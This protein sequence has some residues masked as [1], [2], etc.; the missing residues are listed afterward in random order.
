MSIIYEVILIGGL[1]K[2]WHSMTKGE[3][4][5]KCTILCDIFY[6]QRWQLTE[7]KTKISFNQR[8]YSSL[9]K[10]AAHNEEFITDVNFLTANGT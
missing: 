8:H 5:Q 7:K 3:G 4:V 2:M 6:E 10:F 1:K 9:Q